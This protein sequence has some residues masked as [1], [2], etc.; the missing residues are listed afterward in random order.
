MARAPAS[1]T[2]ELTSPIAVGFSPDVERKVKMSGLVAALSYA[3]DITEGQPAGHAARTCLIGMRLAELLGLPVADRSDL[4]YALLLK[5][6]G[7]SS[8]ASKMCYLFGADDRTVKR[9]LKSVDWPKMSESFKF[10]TKQVSPEGSPVQRALKIAAML[11]KGPKGAQQ[12]VE[13]RCER[14]AEIA[15]GMGFSDGVAL[16]IT[17]LDEHWDGQ[18]HP[19]GRQG[20]EISPLARI[21]GLAQTFE[22]FHAQLGRDAALAMAATRSGGWFEPALVELLAALPAD[23]RLWADLRSGEPDQLVTQYEPDD[24][25]MMIDELGVDR[26]AEGFAQVVDAKSPWTFRHSD[27]VARIAVGM[28]ERLG[29]TP[30]EQRAIRRMALLHDLGKLGVSNAVLDKPGRPTDDEFAQLKRHPRYTHDILVRAGCFQDLADVAA[31]HHEKLDG[32]GYHR[33]IP[34]AELPIGA[35][36][37]C[38]ADMYEAMTASRPYR[39]GMPQEKVLGILDSEAGT[40]ICPE[41]VA[42]LKLWLS[43]AEFESRVNDQMQALDRLMDELT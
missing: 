32:R 13:T 1:L 19:E 9:D 20:L 26:V 4:F 41:S 39:E 25:V 3:L 15:R 28:G 8:N 31:A 22:V 36:L 33:G 10:L 40:Q 11:L 23:D 21:A 18:G 37:L 6:L 42:S 14:G 5:D 34:A 16:A 27:E 24:R 35:R 43:H 29:F 7:C 12:L 38:V 2:P 30:A 17:H